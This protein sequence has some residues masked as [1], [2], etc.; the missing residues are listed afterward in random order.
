MCIVYRDQLGNVI[1]WVDDN[2]IQ[3]LDGTAYFSDISGTEY[4]VNVSNI[5]EITA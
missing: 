5:V 1:Q 4:R 2:G 3:F